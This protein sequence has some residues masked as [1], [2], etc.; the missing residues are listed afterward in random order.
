MGRYR[1]LFEMS[2]IKEKLDPNKDN[3]FEKKFKGKVFDS[4]EGMLNK[5]DMTDISP[6]L[7]KHRKIIGFVYDAD[8]DGTFQGVDIED[9]GMFRT[10]NGIDVYEM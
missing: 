6:V 2:L 7:D 8:T 5:Y 9:F 3:G 10:K 4:V 1:E